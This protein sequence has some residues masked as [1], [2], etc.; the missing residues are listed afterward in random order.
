MKQGHELTT[1]YSR[2]GADS[3][4]LFLHGFTGD[5]D[6]T[7]DRFPF[8]LG[9]EESLRNWDILSLGYHT[10]FLPGTRGIWAAD[11]ELPILATLFGTQLGIRSHQA[12]APPFPFRYAG[13]CQRV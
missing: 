1:V 2:M 4:I 9:A 3:A 5:A 11:P 10:S 8:A 12:C 6:E 7:W 13:A